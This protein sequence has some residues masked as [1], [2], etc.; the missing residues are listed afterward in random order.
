[1]QS[2]SHLEGPVLGLMLCLGNLEILNDFVKRISVFL[3][4]HW[5]SPMISVVSS[6]PRIDHGLLY[7][8]WKRKDVATRKHWLHHWQEL[9]HSQV[10][11]WLLLPYLCLHGSVIACHPPFQLTE[12]M[13][14]NSDILER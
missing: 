1:M 2:H 9:E 10:G 13:F 8:L 6:S 4:L 3:T 12:Q 11:V 5:V 14:S 7:S